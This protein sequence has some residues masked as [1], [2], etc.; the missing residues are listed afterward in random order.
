M[1]WTRD[2]VPSY[3]GLP[4]CPFVDRGQ[5]ADKRRP[6]MQMPCP[7]RAAVKGRRDRNSAHT[8][9]RRVRPHLASQSRT[10]DRGQLA[11]E[12]DLQVVSRVDRFMSAHDLLPA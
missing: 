5:L 6:L 11:A 4:A 9:T 1:L 10:V 2:S 3:G 8:K 12:R 7:I